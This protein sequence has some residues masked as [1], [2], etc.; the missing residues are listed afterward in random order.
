MKSNT[1][2]CVLAFVAALALTLEIAGVRGAAVWRGGAPLHKYPPSVGSSGYHVNPNSLSRQTVASGGTNEPHEK[3]A[4]DAFDFANDFKY[5]D[6][7]PQLHEATLTSHHSPQMQNQP[8][9]KQARYSSTGDVGNADDEVLELQRLIQEA[10]AEAERPPV[11]EIKIDNNTDVTSTS[12]LIASLLPPHS[13]FTVKINHRKDI[14]RTAAVFVDD[15]ETGHKLWIA[16]MANADLKD[17]VLAQ[18]RNQDTDIL[19]F[20]RMLLKEKL[21]TALFEQILKQH[22]PRQPS[23]PLAA[24]AASSMSNTSPPPTS[25]FISALEQS[26]EIAEH[27]KWAVLHLQAQEQQQLLVK[28]RYVTYLGQ[29]LIMLHP[30]EKDNIVYVK[31]EGLRNITEKSAQN[32]GAI[33]QLI[34]KYYGVNP[35]YIRVIRSDKGHFV[36]TVAVLCTNK[37][38]AEK[39]KS[40]EEP[41]NLTVKLS[42]W[43]TK[44]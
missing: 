28:A 29:H 2:I 43:G 27:R 25:Y 36:G 24:A 6:R 15:T 39:M 17:K 1:S 5:R 8:P 13:R 40:K 4:S 16:M 14:G 22:G 34:S 42:I 7:T 23:S 33:Y 31:L 32:G 19:I 26:I 30:K 38:D 20:G 12:T 9:T 18:V 3:K 10:T 21:A 11:V 37:E 41:P 44:K 35:V